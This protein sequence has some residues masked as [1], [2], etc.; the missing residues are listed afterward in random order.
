MAEVPPIGDVEL[1]STIQLNALGRWP[2][3]VRRDLVT[4]YLGILPHKPAPRLTVE[5]ADSIDLQS[6]GK[7]VV[8]SLSSHLYD[9]CPSNP[10]PPPSWWRETETLPIDIQPG[11]DIRPL[12][13]SLE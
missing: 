1:L 2:A 6:I 7:E 3:D 10:P 13:D 9:R 12:A 11:E 8:V 4:A 5:V